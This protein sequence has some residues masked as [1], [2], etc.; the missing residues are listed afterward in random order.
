[1][2]GFHLLSRDKISDAVIAPVLVVKFT[3]D[4]KT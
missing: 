2:S 1:M 3:P 4:K